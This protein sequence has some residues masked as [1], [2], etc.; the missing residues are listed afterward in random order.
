MAD[1]FE[2]N[3]EVFKPLSSFFVAN[4]VVTG[5]YYALPPLGEPPE[6]GEPFFEDYRVS[7]PGRPFVG[8]V[9]SGEILTPIWADIILISALANLGATKKTLLRDLKQLARYTVTLPDGDSYDGCAIWDRLPRPTRT[10]IAPGFI[11]LTYHSV[12]WESNSDTN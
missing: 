10:T 3:D 12:C 8:K 1:T 5:L 6:A 9:R 11:A 4:A 2:A 7:F